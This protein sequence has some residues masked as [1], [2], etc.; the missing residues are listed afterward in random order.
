[1]K[2][3]A[4][5]MILFALAIGYFGIYKPRVQKEQA[6]L[7]MQEVARA[8][9]LFYQDCKMF[10][11]VEQGLVLLV[12]KPADCKNWQGPYLQ[13]ENLSDPWGRP[14]LYSRDQ[15]F[16]SLRSLGADGAAGGEGVDA[17]LPEN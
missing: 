17:D 3:L 11:A 2:W 9:D 5:I 16:Y 13:K 8:L 12:D 14:Y 1:M 4:S 15:E 7:H 10:P 6:L